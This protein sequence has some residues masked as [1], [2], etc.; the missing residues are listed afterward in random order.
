METVI[1]WRLSMY[2]QYDGHR[3]TGQEYN[4]SARRMQ[5]VRAVLTAN[6]RARAAAKRGIAS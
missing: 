4:Q 1:Q 3:K 2:Q 6:W 5:K